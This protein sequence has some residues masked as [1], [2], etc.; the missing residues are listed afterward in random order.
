MA[1]DTLSVKEVAKLLGLN[2]ST[3][4]RKRERGELVAHRKAEAWM[5][6]L[7]WLPLEGTRH[8]DAHRAEREAYFAMQDA[9]DRL[10][11]ALDKD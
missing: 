2:P 5:E 6:E 3:V 9:L 1:E 11:A 4:R 8:S 7:R 10:H